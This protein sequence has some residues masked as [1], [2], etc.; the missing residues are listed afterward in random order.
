[1]VL[2]AE[3]VVEVM[4]SDFKDI[5]GADGVVFLYFTACG[6]SIAIDYLCPIV[7]GAY[8]GIAMAVAFFLDTFSVNSGI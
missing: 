8:C 5:G 1:M 7:I 2:Q 4:G 6:I 3:M